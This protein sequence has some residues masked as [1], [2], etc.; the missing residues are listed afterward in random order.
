[1]NHHGTFRRRNGGESGCALR[2]MVLALF[3]AVTMWLASPCRA[4][5]AGAEVHGA[6]VDESI[7]FYQYTDNDGVIHFVDSREKIPRRYQERV[8]VRKDAP[9]ALQTTRVVIADN[10][11]H[12]PVSFRNGDKTVQAILILDTGASITSITEALATRLG[13]DP[14]SSRAVS[15]GMADG[16]MIDI[17]VTKLDAVGV[18]GRMKF[19]FE[20]GI[21]PDSATRQEHDGYLGVDF[22]SSFPYLVDFQNN[23]IR[24]Q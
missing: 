13:I 3:V 9:A 10:Q 24:W 6:P 23:L 18:G 21:L 19:S 17:R 16:R 5:P 15:M 14:K 11:I 2:R 7:D 1:M 8:I 22:L 4:E 12:V 20:I